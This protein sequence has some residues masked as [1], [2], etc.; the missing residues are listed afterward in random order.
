MAESRIKFESHCW[1]LNHLNKRASTLHYA[2]QQAKPYS[3]GG[4]DTAL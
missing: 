1:N 4:Q 2:D 3:R